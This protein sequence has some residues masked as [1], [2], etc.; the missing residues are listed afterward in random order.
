MNKIQILNSIIKPEICT[1]L[2]NKIKQPE[3]ITPTFIFREIII[4]KLLQKYCNWTND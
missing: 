1:N 3:D 4:N 2:A